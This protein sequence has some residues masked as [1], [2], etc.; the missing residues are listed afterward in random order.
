MKYEIIYDADI[1]EI[2]FNSYLP[3][4][5]EKDL[6]EYT[7]EE[8]SNIINEIIDDII[9]PEKPPQRCLIYKK[10]VNKFDIMIVKYREKNPKLKGGKSGGIRCLLLKDTYNRR[11]ILLHVFSKKEKDDLTETQKK[12]LKQLL[13]IYVNSIENK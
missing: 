6:K 8:L 12:Q 5:L 13:E 3:F 10:K 2:L 9:K 11:G 7:E 1:I 4:S